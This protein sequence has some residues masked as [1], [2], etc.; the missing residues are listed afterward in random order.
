MQPKEVMTHTTNVFFK[1]ISVTDRENP[2]RIMWPKETTSSNGLFGRFVN[3]LPNLEGVPLRSTSEYIGV[4]VQKV[5][6]RGQPLFTTSQINMSVKCS[7]CVITQEPSVQTPA[8]S[9]W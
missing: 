2:F 7:D 4:P 1:S 6:S 9:P 5:M 3:I 8:I